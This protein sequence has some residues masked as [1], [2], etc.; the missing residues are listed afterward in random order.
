MALSEAWTLTTAVSKAING[1]NSQMMSAIT[2]YTPQQES[3]SKARAFDIMMW[4]IRARCQ[5]SNNVWL[6]HILHMGTLFE[7]CAE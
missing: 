4:I 5:Q 2:G 6:G 1:A 7:Y 3:S